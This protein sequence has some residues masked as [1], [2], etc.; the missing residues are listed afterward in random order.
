MGA[1]SKRSGGE[2]T[3][4]TEVEGE[5]AVRKELIRL[6]PKRLGGGK[7]TDSLDEM[8]RDAG[9]TPFASFET[10]RTKLRIHGV[11]IDAD[12]ASFGHSVV[13]VEVMCDSEDQVPAAE[14]RIAQV[15]SAMGLQSLDGGSGGKLET[16]IRRFCP[17][18]FN[19]LVEAGILRT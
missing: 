5:D 12:E 6:L 19:N 10:V 3:V 18:V 16:Y 7:G 9:L 17:E 1:D 4:F 13:E 2:R 15:A 14:V 8:L 11:A